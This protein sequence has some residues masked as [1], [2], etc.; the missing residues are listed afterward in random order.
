[1]FAVSNEDCAAVICP[2]KT[3]RHIDTER[4]TDRDRHRHRDSD[5][6]RQRQR[7]A[8]LCL[9]L[10]LCEQSLSWRLRLACTCATQP[11]D[12]REDQLRLF[13]MGVESPNKLL[14]RP[15]RW[16]KKENKVIVRTSN[17]L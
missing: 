10:C 8:A 16:S 3:V 13:N 2:V 1:M 4:D 5:R 15:N 12:E 11:D 7:A 17:L 14:S 6:D 9:C